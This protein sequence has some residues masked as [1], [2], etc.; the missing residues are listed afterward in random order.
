MTGAA[1]LRRVLGGKRV[2]LGD[3]VVVV[4]GGNTAID[5]ASVARRLGARATILYRRTTEEMPA[6]A[7][8][9]ARALEEGVALE[10]QTAPVR[11]ERDDGRAV[12]LT[13]VRTTMSDPDRSGRRR[14]VPV[15][16]SEHV[17]PVSFVVVAAA[18][19]PDAVGFESILGGRGRICVD[20]GWRTSSRRVWAGGDAIERPGGEL[21]VGLVAE[22]LRHGRMAAVAIHAT[23]VGEPR[24]SP[25]A[26]DVV[27][28]GE[29]KVA[30]YERRARATIRVAPPEERIRRLDLEGVE[31]LDPAGAADEARRC[32]SCGQCFQCELCYLYCQDQAVRKGKAG[33]PY[34]Y[35][36]DLCQGCRKCAEECPCAYL[37]M[38]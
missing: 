35:D 32:M 34:A 13:C 36:L 21:P 24:S 2:E 31:G 19:E 15:E 6:I 7:H 5:A 1:L 4:G 33:E 18:Q 22:A 10:F 16:G 28:A 23:F 14:P 20:D 3:E 17:R 29:V 37:V 25:A 9:V 38:R 30:A 26:V 27:K 8:E 12:A 11:I